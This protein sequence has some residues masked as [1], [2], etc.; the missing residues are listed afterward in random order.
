M[1]KVCSHDE[2]RYESIAEHGRTIDLAACKHY[3]CRISLYYCVL[4]GVTGHHG[5]WRNYY[6]LSNPSPIENDGTGADPNVILDLN[7]Y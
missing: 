3:F 1:G 6:A 4:W 5:V 2:F 7:A